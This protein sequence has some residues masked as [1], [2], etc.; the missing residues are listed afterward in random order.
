MENKSTVMAEYDSKCR[1][2]ENFASEIEHQLK[3]ILVAEGIVYNAITSRV[4]DRESLSKK[5][6]RKNDKYSSLSD[7]TD[8]AGVR[9]ITYYEKD[10]DEVSKI[11]EKEFAVD[12]ENSID[13][14][15]ALEPDRF[16]Y[17]SVHYIV[18]MSLERLNLREN[19]PYAGLKC[20]IQIRTVLQH[21]WAEIEHDLGYKSGIAIPKDIR[22]NFSRVA[23]M[24]EIADK[25]FQEIRT[26]LQDYQNEA[27]EK[28]TNEEFQDA[29]IDAILLEA[30]IASNPDIVTLNKIISKYFGR[31]FSE[32]ISTSSLE[33]K[34]DA[35][36]WLGIHTISQLNDCIKNNKDN[37]AIIAEEFILKDTTDEDSEEDSK[38]SPLSKT[39]AL[40]YI[41]Y[42][43][44]IRENLE[45]EQIMQYFK[46]N[47]IGRGP[48]RA[49]GVRHLLEVGRKI[50][51]PS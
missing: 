48:D 23:G 40:F 47:K 28:V 43:E 39:I 11:V 37:A 50:N 2:Y 3:H 33:E 13:K 18:Q 5:I 4:K 51:I 25:E 49:K 44:I 19:Q 6:D 24:L 41:C 32:E 16:G 7:L 46:D 21:A 35:L 27:T 31:P 45:F 9:V 26:F 1:L 15:A 8:I 14:R 10:V 20:E 22:R 17:C 30:I 12:K 29:E 42:A 34:I 38:P 36:H